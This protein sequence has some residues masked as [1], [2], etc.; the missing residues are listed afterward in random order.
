[1]KRK[2]N[3]EKPVFVMGITD[4]NITIRGTKKL[5]WDTISSLEF[6]CKI[7]EWFINQDFSNI[8]KLVQLEYNWLRIPTLSV[9][10]AICDF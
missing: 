3:T 6:K 1:M 2:Q 5:N 8:I 7:L 9:L 4:L 10:Y